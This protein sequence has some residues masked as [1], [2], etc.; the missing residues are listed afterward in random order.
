MPNAVAVDE[1]LIAAQ[2]ENERELME[3]KAEL[4]DAA[5]VAKCRLW[6]VVGLTDQ[7]VKESLQSVA[8]RAASHLRAAQMTVDRLRGDGPPIAPPQPLQPVK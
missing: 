3:E 4:Q 1:V 7:G 6:E 2:L 5:R 8:S